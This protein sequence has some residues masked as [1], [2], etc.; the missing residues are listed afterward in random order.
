MVDDRTSEPFP[1]IFHIYVQL[2]ILPEGNS[3]QL[4]V[5]ST[6]LIFKTAAMP[7]DAYG[8]LDSSPHPDAADPQIS[9]IWCIID[10]I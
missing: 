1:I 10:R 7:M 4:L 6:K 2:P 5:H 3:K 9:F 8:C